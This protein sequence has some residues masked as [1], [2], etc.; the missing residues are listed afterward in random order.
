M[1][2]FAVMLAVTFKFDVTEAYA[3]KLILTVLISKADKAVFLYNN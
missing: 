2:Q 3:G 1:V